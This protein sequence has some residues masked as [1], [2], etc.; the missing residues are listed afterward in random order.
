MIL[1]PP[2]STLFPY[3]TLFRSERYTLRGARLHP[4]RTG[5]GLRAGIEP[6]RV[7]GLLEERGRGIVG[8]ADRQGAMTLRFPEACERERGR[9][10]CRHPDEHVRRPDAV[11]PYEARA[12]RGFILRTLDRLDQRL[13]A[14]RDQQQQAVLRPAEGRHQFGAVL[15]REAAG[16]PRTCIDEPAAMPEARFRSQCR[17]F[18]R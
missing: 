15:D 16:G 1:R 11:L 10:A 7:L 18:E 17:M 6:D 4:R 2:S 13:H 14:T 5:D 3:T 8:D 9:T 12:L